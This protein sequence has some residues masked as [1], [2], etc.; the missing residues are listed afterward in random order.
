[1]L[2]CPVNEQRVGKGIRVYLAADLA[3][4]QI[5]LHIT[6]VAN[7]TLLANMTPVFATL[8]DG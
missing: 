5:S 4:W 6:S 7:S 1:M 2:Q 8:G 3:A